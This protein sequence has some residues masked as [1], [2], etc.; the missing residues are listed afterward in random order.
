MITFLTF[1]GLDLIFVTAVCDERF[2]GDFLV[3]FSETCMY[4]G[5]LVKIFG[6]ASGLGDKMSV[7]VFPRTVL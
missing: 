2:L 6:I 3:G 4:D 5:K 1:E 7:Q